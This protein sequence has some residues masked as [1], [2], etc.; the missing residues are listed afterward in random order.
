MDLS[1]GL[2]RADIRANAIRITDW[3]AGSRYDM[4][5]S[6]RID[7]LEKYQSVTDKWYHSLKKQGI[8]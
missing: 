5:F 2:I 1:M 3:E 4:S 8:K 7:T 6:V